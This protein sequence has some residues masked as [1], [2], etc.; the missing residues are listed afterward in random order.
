MFVAFD[1]EIALDGS[2]LEQVLT[3]VYDQVG[4]SSAVGRRRGHTFGDGYFTMTIQTHYIGGMDD[5]GF[6]RGRAINNWLMRMN[7]L[8]A[9]SDIPLMAAM[10]PTFPAA[11]GGAVVNSSSIDS[12]G[13]RVTNLTT[14][15]T[16]ILPNMYLMQNNRLFFV[17]SKSANSRALTLFPSIELKNGDVLGRGLTFRGQLT[18]DNPPGAIAYSR[19]ETVQPRLNFTEV[20]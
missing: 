20:L 3:P 5:E 19:N 1:P 15:R 2:F 18:N 13:Q 16:D 11:N 4:S 14:P 9:Y 8:E 10:F 17:L 6:V 12:Q 7:A